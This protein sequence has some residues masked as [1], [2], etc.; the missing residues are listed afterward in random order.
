MDELKSPANDSKSV[1]QGSENSTSR[2]QAQTNEEWRQEYTTGIKV[3]PAALQNVTAG[4]PAP[5]VRSIPEPVLTYQ[6]HRTS[7]PNLRPE[8]PRNLKREQGSLILS[9]VDTVTGEEVVAFFNVKTKRT[10]GKYEGK[11]YRTGEGGQFNPAPRSKFRKFWM[12]AVNQAPRQWSRVH[13]KLKLKLQGL[14]FTG[15]L[16]TVTTGSAAPYTMVANLRKLVLSDCLAIAYEVLNDCLTPVLN[17]P[18]QTLSVK[19]FQGNQS[20]Q[21]GKCPDNLVTKNPNTHTRYNY[22]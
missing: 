17:D 9:F 12:N 2:V 22:Y 18:E 20:T 6:G 14:N 10:R 13:N 15:E 3:Q 21:H 8:T 4:D 7:K 19:G 5:R 11:H 16:K 1:S